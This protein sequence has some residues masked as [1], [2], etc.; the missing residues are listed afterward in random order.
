MGRPAAGRARGSARRLRMV[1]A[2]TGSALLRVARAHPGA[3]A[4]IVI[5]SGASGVFAWNALTQPTRH[6]APLFADRQGAAARVEPPRRSDVLSTSGTPSPPRKA[7][8]PSPE[9]TTRT[10][11]AT[12]PI[13]ALIRA[14][15][16]AGRATDATRIASA[17]RALNKL[18]YGP[19]KADGVMGTTTRQATEKFERAQSLPVTGTLGQRT[20]RQLAAISGLPVE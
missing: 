11:G 16:P 20:A 17:Q 2:R 12:D 14:S 9:N 7:E 13:G 5:A 3:V 18:G 10:G 1:G 19:L 15:E 8:A 4:A 6:P